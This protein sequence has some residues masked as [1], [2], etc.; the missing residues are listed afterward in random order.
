MYEIARWVLGW[1]DVAAVLHPT[2]LRQRVQSILRAALPKC[3]DA[4]CDQTDITVKD[5][6]RLQ[7]SFQAV[8]A[9]VGR[10]RNLSA[11][12]VLQSPATNP[13]QQAAN[14]QGAL[15]NSR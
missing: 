7:K 12:G 14:F 4:G 6:G 2:E 5:R 15:P 1:G 9:K 8:A 11:L 13:F 3:S 10:N